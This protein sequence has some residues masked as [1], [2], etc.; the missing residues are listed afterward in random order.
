MSTGTPVSSETAEATSSPNGALKGARVNPR[1]VLT[2]LAERPSASA[3]IAVLGLSLFM[4]IW[5]PAAFPNQE[6]LDLVARSFSFIAIAAVGELTV[7]L[8]KGIDISVGS[9]MGLAGISTAMLSAHGVNPV[10]SILAGLAIGTSVGV[11]NGFAIAFMGLTAFMVTLATLN[12]VR[13]FDVVITQGMPVTGMSNSILALGEGSLLGI[14]AP[15]WIMLVVA[16]I[17]G[18]VLTRV[19][20]GRHVYAIG[21]NERAAELSG[22]RVKAVKM[23]CYVACSFFAS[24]GGILL[25]ARLGVGE[26]ESGFGYE[27]NIIAATVIGGASFFGGIGNVFGV[28]W[29]A[30]LLGL[31]VNAMAIAGVNAYWQQIVIGLVIFLAVLIDRYRAPKLAR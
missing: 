16:L 13:G 26:P 25:T 9:V 14:P 22:V 12:V 17:W 27:L 3:V 19:T 20:F 1:R 29:G 2:N 28:I 5:S 4:T 31:V 18:F 10:L 30:A 11:V 24:L 7:I 15:V 8:T 21:G 6:N 23:A